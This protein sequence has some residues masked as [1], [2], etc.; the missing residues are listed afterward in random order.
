MS[1]SISCPPLRVARL[2]LVPAGG[3][4]PHRV[5]RPFATSNVASPAEHWQHVRREWDSSNLSRDFPDDSS[6]APK[7]IAQ[8]RIERKRKHPIWIGH[9]GWGTRCFRDPTKA[10]SGARRRSLGNC[11]QS[12]G[13]RFNPIAA[14]TRG[15]MSALAS[16][17][18]RQ[19]V[20]GFPRTAAAAP[21]PRQAGRC[22]RK[23]GNG[24][25]LLFSGVSY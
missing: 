17:A 10:H 7:A 16:A 8:S 21:P 24:D 14:M 15:V 9:L 3:S 2:F 18:G 11:R 23:R 5:T 20:A 12:S 13:R 25:I 19:S 22:A 6:Q 4:T 1:N